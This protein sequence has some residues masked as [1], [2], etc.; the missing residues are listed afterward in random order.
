MGMGLRLDWDGAAPRLEALHRNV[1]RMQRSI[2]RQHGEDVSG[3]A[4][5]GKQWMLV[6]VVIV[7][8]G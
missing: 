4:Q 3:N 1:L 6:E 8:A 7:V 2:P 5:I